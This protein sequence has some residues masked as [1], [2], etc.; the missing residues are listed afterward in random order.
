MLPGQLTQLHIFEPR[1]KQ[2][3]GDCQTNDIK[4]GIPY[5]KDGKTM[6]YGST[7]RLERVI[8]KYKT[9]EMDVEIRGLDIISI[10]SFYERHPLKLYPAGTVT[11]MGSDVYRAETRTINEL[12]K[13]AFRYM[14][15]DKLIKTISGNI[16]E[17]AGLLSLTEEQKYNVLTMFNADR[18]NKL[19]LNII[20]TR[21][22]LL[23][24]ESH[25][26]GNY[27]LN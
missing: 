22:A 7:A 1:Y 8:T 3:F 19:L 14:P 20:R 17:I 11:E 25:L 10:D 15:K 2:L 18:M 13:F 4:F 26:Q 12:K 6:E 23:N 16:F 27:Y 9:G 5:V 24:Q 21:T